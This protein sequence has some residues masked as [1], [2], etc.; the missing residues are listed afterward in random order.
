MTMPTSQ[1]NILN[2]HQPPMSQLFTFSCMCYNRSKYSHTSAI[3][4]PPLNNK[5]VTQVTGTIRK[6]N[7]IYTYWLIFQICFE[8]GCQYVVFQQWLNDWITALGWVLCLFLPQGFQTNISSS[9]SYTSIRGSF[10]NESFQS[11]Q[12]T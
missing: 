9:V 2:T 6:H 4:Q 3:V 7:R 11:I 5:L 12:H 10:P 8:D 1:T